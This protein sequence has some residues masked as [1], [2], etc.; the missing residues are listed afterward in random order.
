MLLL[1]KEGLGVVNPNATW[2][3]PLLNSPPLEE[4]YPKGEVVKLYT[5]L[6]KPYLHKNKDQ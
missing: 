5:F 2:H 3:N 6:P 4:E 1:I